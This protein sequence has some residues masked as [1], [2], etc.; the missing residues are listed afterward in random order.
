MIGRLCLSILLLVAVFPDATSVRATSQNCLSYETD[1]VKLVGKLLRK[2]FPGPPNYQSLKKGDQPEVEW[3]LRLAKPICVKADKLNEYNAAE[4]NVSDV[5][6]VLTEEQ[7]GQI[8]RRRL[9][10]AVAITGQLFHA[11][12]GHHHTRVLMAVSKLEVGG[13]K[14]GVK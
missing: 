2:T 9:N 14:G 11:H 7:S 10:R 6:L 4:R 12:T 5:Q 1:G 13:V 8:R 3:I